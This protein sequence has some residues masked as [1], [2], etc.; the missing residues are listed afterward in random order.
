MRETQHRRTVRAQYGQSRLLL[1]TRQG[2]THALLAN[3][4]WSAAEILE[5]TLKRQ[6][7]ISCVVEAGEGCIGPERAIRRHAEGQGAGNVAADLCQ[8]AQNI[9]LIEAEGSGQNLKLLFLW[10]EVREP[11][12]DDVRGIGIGTERHGDRKR[13]C[14][15]RLQ[16]AICI[17]QRE[18][19]IS[20]NV[21]PPYRQVIKPDGDGGGH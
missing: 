16:P 7:R 10:Q 9:R 12:G 3:Q 8:H 17:A 6:T 19:S 11:R 20:R 2:L 1:A 14:P 5:V 15:G 21:D 4:K 18:R 13:E